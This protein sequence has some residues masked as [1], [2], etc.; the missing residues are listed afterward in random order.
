M[1]K[2]TAAAFMGICMLF[3]AW[4]T[5]RAQQKT[6]KAPP[7]KQVPATGCPRN[8]KYSSAVINGIRFGTI[9]YA[10]NQELTTATPK[11][12]QTKEVYVFTSIPPT[13]VQ[14][15]KE[16]GIRAGAAFTRTASGKFQYLCDVNPNLDFRDILKIFGVDMGENVDRPQKP[17]FEPD[18]KAQTKLKQLHDSIVLDTETMLKNKVEEMSQ[19]YGYKRFITCLDIVVTKE[20]HLLKSLI[21]TPAASNASPLI[22]FVIRTDADNLLIVTPSD[23]RAARVGDLNLSDSGIQRAMDAIKAS[24]NPN[25]AFIVVDEKAMGRYYDDELTRL[26]MN[27]VQIAK[28]AI[29]ESSEDKGTLLIAN[30]T[31]NYLLSDNSSAPWQGYIKSVVSPVY[32]HPAELMNMGG[33][34]YSRDYQGEKGNPGWIFINT[35]KPALIDFSAADLEMIASKQIS[36]A[37]KTQTATLIT[38]KKIR[39]TINGISAVNDEFMKSSNKHW[40]SVLGI[41]APNGFSITIEDIRGSKPLYMTGEAILNNR[42]GICDRLPQNIVETINAAFPGIDKLSA[43]FNDTNPDVRKSAIEELVKRVDTRSVDPRYID[44]FANALRDHSKDVRETAV[45]ALAATGSKQAL[46]QL[47]HALRDEDSGLRKRV[48]ALLTSNNF[49]P[50]N[51][52]VRADYLMAGEK[53][54]EAVEPLLAL[55]GNS[56]PKIRK[57]AIDDLGRIKDS[58]SVEPLTAALSDS[59][60]EVR[61]AAQSAL[62]KIKSANTK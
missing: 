48:Y 17:Y 3:L 50:E 20:A 44:A 23:K 32:G 5:L 46:E 21:Q 42:D 35:R 52:V 6:S 24:A 25:P 11:A 18:A 19:E 41:S 36:E 49:K 13:Q 37:D 22:V 56:D 47:S 39:I 59:D 14:R 4:H 10:I 2:A 58:R 61:K 38:S 28:K 30:R 34:N 12:K 54:N 27:A 55:L 31:P 57:S 60:P 33:Q 8:A 26:A 43:F 15:S 40:N 29:S 7:A 45:F 9:D 53:W 62:S 51:D 16:L 1:K